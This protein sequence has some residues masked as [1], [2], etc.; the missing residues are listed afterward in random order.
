MIGNMFSLSMLSDPFISLK[1][2]IYYLLVKSGRRAQMIS[3]CA[4]DILG[5]GSYA[6]TDI[7]YKLLRIF[8]NGTRSH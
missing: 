7:N 5:S 6:V 4:V 2:D 8:V 1:S 3:S